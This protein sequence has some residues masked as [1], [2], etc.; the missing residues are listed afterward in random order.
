MVR[1]MQ[2]RYRKLLGLKDGVLAEYRFIAFCTRYAQ[3]NEDRFRQ[4]HQ[5]MQLRNH[6]ESATASPQHPIAASPQPST[7][8]A[9]AA[10]TWNSPSP[11]ASASASANATPEPCT[12]SAASEY[13]IHEFTCASSATPHDITIEDTP[14]STSAAVAADF[15]IHEFKDPSISPIV[16]RKINPSF[17]D[18]QLFTPPSLLQSTQDV[19]DSEDDT[20]IIEDAPPASQDVTDSE[21]DITIEDTPASQDVTG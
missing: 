20:I 14:A 10:M 16:F 7:S 5:F 21:D 13:F 19:T 1:V 9:P 11:Q 2:E 18:T 12:S 17:I 6:V 4:L 3:D 15:F 8:S